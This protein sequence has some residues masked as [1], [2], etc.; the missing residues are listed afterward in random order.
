[1]KGKFV[2]EHQCFRFRYSATYLRVTEVQISISLHILWQICPDRIFVYVIY[3]NRIPRQVLLKNLGGICKF[4]EDYIL[5]Q[6]P[7]NL[8]K[9]FEMCATN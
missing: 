3:I 5:G 8:S 9:N 4:W 2:L 7:R 1:M 6:V